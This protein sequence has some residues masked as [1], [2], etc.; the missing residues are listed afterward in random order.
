MKKSLTLW[1]LAGFVFTGLAGTLLNFLYDWSGQSTIVAPFAAINESIWEHMK[2]LFVPMFLFALTEFRILGDQ[3]EN[4][5][6]SKLAG[7][8]VGLILIPSL[9]YTYTG[10]FGVSLDW[11]NI[12]IFFLAAA[13]AF[14]LETRLLK[15]NHTFGIS[16]TLALILLCLIAIAFM[17]LTF[18]QP[19]IPLFQD[20]TTKLYGMNK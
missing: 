2:I 7:T 5:W 6:C 3:Y 8:L 15:Q 17:I 14:F 18:V 4:F 11:I 20:P 1:Q 12:V 10:I 19:R 9:Y 13:T 16:N